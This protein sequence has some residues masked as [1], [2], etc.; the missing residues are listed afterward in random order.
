M[1]SRVKPEFQRYSQHNYQG[2]EV[3]S[4][5]KDKATDT[6]INREAYR[7]AV[8]KQI[9]EKSRQLLTPEDQKV[10]EQARLLSIKPSKSKPLN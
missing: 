8:F 7:E 3:M 4:E 1:E 5:S 9:H 2:E 6:A 10:L